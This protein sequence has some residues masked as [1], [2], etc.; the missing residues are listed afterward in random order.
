MA[1]LVH[2]YMEYWELVG[3][4]QCKPN[5]NPAGTVTFSSFLLKR[6]FNSVRIPGET[7]DTIKT[8]FIPFSLG[9]CPS[10]IVFFG[11]GRIFIV[12]GTHDDGSIMSVQEVYAALLQIRSLMDEQEGIHLPVP[13][14]THDD[15]TG[16]ANVSTTS[17]LQ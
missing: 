8:H 13:I 11:R 5:T 17:I 14:L 3:K 16:W 6:F 7:M 2:V 1:R 9:N 12:K 10:N 15:R 4:E